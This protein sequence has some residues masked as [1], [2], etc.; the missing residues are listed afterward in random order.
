MARTIIDDGATSPTYV[1]DDGPAVGI[2]IGLLI[3]VAAV[4]L[5]VLFVRGTFT[6]STPGTG[7]PDDVVPTAPASSEPS[8]VPSP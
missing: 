8:S 4:V 7:N 6:D 5:G 3:A 1:E 2:L